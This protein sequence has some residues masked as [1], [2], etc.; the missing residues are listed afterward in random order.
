MRARR[1]DSHAPARGFSLIEVLVTI[2]V[3]V[4]G[5][6]GM[7]G[8]QSRASVVEM[9]AYQ[10]AQAL[11]LIKD[12]EARIRTNRAQ[13][14]AG[15]ETA[16][17]DMQSPAVFGTQSTVNCKGATGALLEVCQWSESLL[18]AAEAVSASPTTQV[19]AMIGARG[20]V[21]ALP[22]PTSAAVAEFFVVV[23]WQGLNATGDP[24]AGTPATACAKD[25]DFG[26]G[27][28]RAATVRV[29]VPKLEG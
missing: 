21:M 7:F 2:L 11:A 26:K 12:M 28:R 22:A 8:M 29:L 4:I 6:L 1:S 9:D 10:Q 27:L 18:G 14:N 20:C 25:V 15:F 5:L 17:A 13:F 19:G 3:L 23:V 24:A 16:Y